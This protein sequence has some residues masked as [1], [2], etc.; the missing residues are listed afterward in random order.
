MLRT[1]YLR[2]KNLGHGNAVVDRLEK[3]FSKKEA[4]L[5]RSFRGGYRSLFERSKVDVY[6]KV[7]SM[8]G[9]DFD[10]TRI[11]PEWSEI[12]WGRA[13]DSVQFPLAEST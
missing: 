4:R 12:E 2:V 8:R 11:E 5:R 13:A 3:K 7:E 10:F 9:E 1:I 6:L